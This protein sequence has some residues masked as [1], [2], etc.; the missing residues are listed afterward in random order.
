MTD[1]TVY[2]LGR[3]LVLE[4]L[5][6]NSPPGIRMAVEKVYED[7]AEIEH[8]LEE[9]TRVV[10]FLLDGGDPAQIIKQGG[11]PFHGVQQTHEQTDETNTVTVSSLR[12]PLHLRLLQGHRGRGGPAH[13]LPLHLPVR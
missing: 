5:K 8:R 2:Y 12:G 1:D 7:R 3:P 11:V 13:V 9:T 10:E 6:E 4:W